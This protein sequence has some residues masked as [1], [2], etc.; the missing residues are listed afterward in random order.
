ME[1]KILNKL[2]RIRCPHCENMG[3]SNLMG[4]KRNDDGDVEN[5]F[6]CTECSK[7]FTDHA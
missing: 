1:K 6:E 2:L 7:A 4:T 5:V 3:T